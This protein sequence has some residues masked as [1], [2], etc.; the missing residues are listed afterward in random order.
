MRTIFLAAAAALALGACATDPSA[1]Q[2]AVTAPPAQPAVEPTRIVAPG[3][4][5]AW[6]V[7]GFK[8][9]ESVTLDPRRR[10]LYVS[11]IVGEPAG[12][13]GVGYIS[14]LGFDGKLIQEQWVTGLNAPKG[15]AVR[16]DTLYVSDIDA[17]VVID[18]PSGKVT[19]R[20]AAPGAKFLNDIAVDRRGRVYVSDLMDNAIWRLDG[21]RFGQWLKDDRLTS[22]NGL[23]VRGDDLIVASWGVFSGQGFATTVAGHMK[24]VSLTDKAIRSIGN[25]APVGNLDGLEFLRDGSFLVTDWLSGGLLRIDRTG[26]ATQLVDLP[27]G[28][29]DHAWLPRQKL[30]VVPMMLQGQVVAFRLP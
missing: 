26:K 11:N 7:G 3:V 24:A 5:E 21:K 15:M 9:P 2:T 4:T 27:Q 13:D 10:V 8:M 22:P 29:A 17:L 16:G 1:T 25:G 28:S 12:K 23:Q 18:I 6:R 14:R 20:H 19:A 30:A